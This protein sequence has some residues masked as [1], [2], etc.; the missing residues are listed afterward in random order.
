MNDGELK[1]KKFTPG[2]LHVGS[3]PVGDCIFDWNEEIVGFAFGE[4]S[5]R[6][7]TYSKSDA[8]EEA[9]ANARL[10]AAAP[11]LL[12]AL[13]MV[14]DADNDVKSDGGDGIPPVARASIDRAI[15]KAT[16]VEPKS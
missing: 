4:T 3:V 5:G 10:W 1:T 13:I 2:P 7:F 8:K 9:Q 16:G 15:A 14:R 11:E 6:Y 12:D